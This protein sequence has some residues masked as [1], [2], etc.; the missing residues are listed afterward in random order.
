MDST[1][2]RVVGTLS[3]TRLV[4]ATMTR[5]DFAIYELDKNYREIEGQYRTRP[6]TLASRKGDLGEPIQVLSGYWK[7]GYSCAIEAFIPTLR[8]AGWTMSDSI[9]YSR[10]GCEVIGG[11]S[12]S[13]VV[14]GLTR[15]VIGVNNTGNE[16]GE[17]C[18]MNNPCEVDEAGNI[19][20]EK[21]FSYGQQVRWI[22]GCLASGRTLDLKRPECEL[23]KP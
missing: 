10:P 7:R 19:R 13:P 6:L 18:T 11:T 21:G 3:T 2:Q 20:A 1:G 16:S 4:Y 8:E 9:R 5:T 14:S 15:E 23:P 17:E 12:G 22:Y